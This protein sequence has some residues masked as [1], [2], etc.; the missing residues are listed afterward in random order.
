M[1]TI[2][3]QQ[4]QQ[5]LPIK[6]DP[7]KCHRITFSVQSSLQHAIASRIPAL[8][9][10]EKAIMLTTTAKKNIN[11]TLA[12]DTR[13]SSSG[14]RTNSATGSAPVIVIAAKRTHTL[15]GTA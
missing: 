13:A 2:E 6:K 15:L 7:I 10:G 1:A 3:D 5:Q 4:Q 11:P 9:M 12:C 14:L 8:W